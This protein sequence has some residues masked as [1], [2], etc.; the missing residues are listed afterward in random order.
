MLTIVRPM[1]VI[2]FLALHGGKPLKPDIPVCCRFV[3][4]PDQLRLLAKRLS[5]FISLSHTTGIRCPKRDGRGSK[6]I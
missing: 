6:C 1:F 5:S 3:T 2:E 4:V